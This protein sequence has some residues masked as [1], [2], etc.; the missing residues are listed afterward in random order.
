[1]KRAT[2]IFIISLLAASSAI[3]ADWQG[4]AD[5]V[6]R[7]QPMN[8]SQQQGRL[9]YLPAE[10]DSYYAGA[11]DPLLKLSKR[12]KYHPPSSRIGRHAKVTP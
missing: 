8:A 6:D 10:I 5:L 11:V 2:F 3:A 7:A 12:T 4:I 9:P 1:M